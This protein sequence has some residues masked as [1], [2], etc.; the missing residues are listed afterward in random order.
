MFVDVDLSRWCIIY[1]IR[2]ERETEDFIKCLKN[3]GRGLQY[4]IDEPLKRT[5]S[6]DR[7]DSYLKALD[8]L[9]NKDPRLIMCVVPNNRADRYS[10]IKKRT[11]VDRAVPTQVVLTKTITPKQGAGMGG[12]MS[13]ATKVVLQLNCK[14]G[15]APWMVKLPISGL[16]TIGFDVSLKIKK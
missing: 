11:C 14:L 10:V 6:D 3:V 4:R 2:N 5:I 9:I 16:M 1:P 8:E 15:G 7:S 12:V 13:V